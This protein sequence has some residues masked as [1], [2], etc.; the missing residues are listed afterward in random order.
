MNLL[1]SIKPSSSKNYDNLVKILI[2]LFS[3][4]LALK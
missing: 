4:R 2:N 3:A 1:A